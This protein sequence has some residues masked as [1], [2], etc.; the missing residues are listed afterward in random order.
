MASLKDWKRDKKQAIKKRSKE[1]K[2][3]ERRGIIKW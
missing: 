2:T 3:A 1:K